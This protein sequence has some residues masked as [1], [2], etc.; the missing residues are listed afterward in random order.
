MTKDKTP[1]EI[2]RIIQKAFVEVNE[3]G[4]EAA[5][6]TV[7]IM[8]TES[9]IDREPKIIPHFRADRP[10]LFLIRERKT[11]AVLFTGGIEEPQ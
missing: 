5:A 1:L 11:G 4:T 2:S 3:K 10:F 6:V 8:R 9:S 7:V